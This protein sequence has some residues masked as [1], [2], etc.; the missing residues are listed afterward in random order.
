MTWFEVIRHEA[1]EQIDIVTRTSFASSISPKEVANVIEVLNEVLVGRVAYKLF[2]G[3]SAIAV[4]TQTLNLTFNFSVNPTH[5]ATVEKSI[6]RRELTD[7]R[8]TFVMFVLA[9]IDLK[10]RLNG[11]LPEGFRQTLDMF[12]YIGKDLP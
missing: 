3:L 9:N 8:V 6:G 7:H 1:E 10:Y 2:E 12:E 11:S 5:M 4:D